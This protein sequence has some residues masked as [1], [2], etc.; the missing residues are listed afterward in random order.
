MCV[1]VC[2]CVCVNSWYFKTSYCK[3]FQL[4]RTYTNISI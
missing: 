2:V 3:C 4:F 1:C